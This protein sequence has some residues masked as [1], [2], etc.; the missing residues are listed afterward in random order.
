MASHETNLKAVF[1]LV[2]QFSPALKNMQ[3][4]MRVAGRQMREGFSQLADM[5]KVAAGGVA[6]LSAVGAGTWA[7]TVS[8][9]DSAVQ[10]KQMADQTGVAVDKLQAW[11]TAAVAGGMDADEFAESLR[12]MNI[13]L[14]DAAT[15]GKDELAQLLQKVGIAA[16][17][18]SGNIKTADQVFLDFADAVAAQ[19]DPAIQLRMAISAF[20]EDTGAKLLPIL[21]QGSAAFRESE[22]AMRAA[23]TA[24]TDEQIERMR[25]F[26]NQWNGL[27]KS[28]DTA[29]VSL[30]SNLAPAF[31][32][33]S[34]R[35]AEVFSRIVPVLDS[36]M[37]EWARDLGD[38]ISSINWDA[39]LSG[40]DALLSGG[41]KL[42][43]EFGA[44]GTMIN[45][46]TGN[47]DK[48]VIAFL[49]FKTAV[50]A[51]K[52]GGAFASIGSG[53]IGVLKVMNPQT[54]LTLLAQ[55][56]SG[57]TK[58]VSGSW[59]ALTFLGKAFLRAGPIGWI[60]TALSVASIVWSKWGD[61]IMK[62]LEQ[63]WQ[64]V[65]SFFGQIAD[66]ISEKVDGIEAAF[67]SFVQSLKDLVPDWLLKFLGGSDDKTIGIETSGA[68][69]EAVRGAVFPQGEPRQ[70]RDTPFFET[71]S[72]SFEPTFLQQAAAPSPAEMYG[73]LDVRFAGAPEGMRL[74][75]ANSSKSLTLNTSI[76]YDQGSGRSTYAPA[77]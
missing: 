6:A 17:D 25:A 42:E 24:I 60:L 43:Q 73:R 71:R 4:E 52:I 41:E 62:V 61:D 21:K 74:E 76:D 57:I 7:A 2:D 63:V 70:V 65:S 28:L 3:R 15:G 55:W 68:A 8:A 69:F 34:E 49:G 39:I 54:F 12:D 64:A 66:W 35:L 20:G 40:V 38:W 67:D 59:A 13:E 44:V 1:T 37:E 36:H 32:I 9:A 22:E 75:R 50:A 18:A 19:V 77:W 72:S 10:L 46:V 23:G 53:V 16:R 48:M 51:A 31:S 14:S 5:A 29:R 33:L 56:G 45:F 27:T 26:R 11:Q 30:L 47:L 58:F